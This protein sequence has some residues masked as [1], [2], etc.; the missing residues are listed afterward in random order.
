MD[1]YHAQ[2]T[3]RMMICLFR[4]LSVFIGQSGKNYDEEAGIRCAASG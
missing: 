4:Q 1:T 2:N 3:R